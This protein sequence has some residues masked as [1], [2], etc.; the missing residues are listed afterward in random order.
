ML[1]SNK[2]LG[3][4]LLSSSSDRR[5]LDIV[6]GTGLFAAY[7]PHYSRRTP[8][9]RTFTGCGREIVLVHES[10]A[11][12]WACVYQRT[13]ARRGSGASRGRET[14][15][16]DAPQYLWRNMMFRRL[17]E[18]TVRASNLITTAT[19]ATYQA[20]VQRYGTLPTERLRTEVDIHR[21]QSR[22]PGYCYKVAG[23]IPDKVVHGKL[24]LYAPKA[25]CEGSES[26]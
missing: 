7:G 14:A 5:A 2:V 23:W 22:N 15:P 17:P 16:D 21:V 3:E 9:S 20:W 6:D 8:G 24:Y 1:S 19:T 12:V 10:L 18:C 4:W 13:P 25:T 26:Q 11:A